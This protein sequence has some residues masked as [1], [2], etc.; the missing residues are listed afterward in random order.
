MIK[1]FL[2]NLVVIVNFRVYR[3]KVGMRIWLKFKDSFYW[4]RVKC[5][6][7]IKLVIYLGW[8]MEEVEGGEVGF[9]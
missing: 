2:Y 4:L 3:R 5:E 7:D 9:F 1:L 8:W 6:K